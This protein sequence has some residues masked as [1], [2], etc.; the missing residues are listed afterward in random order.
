MT[1][2]KP[3]FVERF[4]E[5]WREP[6]ILFPKLFHADGTLFQSGMDR[7]ITR[8]EIAAHQQVAMRLM[9]DLD[10]AAT[11]WAESDDDVFI[12]WRARGTFLGT[13]LTWR[14]AS[15]FTLRDGL[16]LE[17]VAY[18]D[19]L[20]LRAAADPS[21]RRGDMVADADLRAAEGAAT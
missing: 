6:L 16:I 13:S 4:E 11:N 17:E 21:L 1:N 3:A 15:R 7:A 8:D 5:A 10:I 2:A 14:G 19:T 20:P 18:F 9:P 12:E